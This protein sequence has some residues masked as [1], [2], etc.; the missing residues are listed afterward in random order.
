MEYTQSDGA[1]HL[2]ERAAQERKGAVAM[3]NPLPNAPF[4]P[5][6][7]AAMGWRGRQGCLLLTAPNFCRAG[8][9]VAVAAVCLESMRTPPD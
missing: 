4:F 9:F 5:L 3:S 7:H 2:R 6:F 1:V 8:L